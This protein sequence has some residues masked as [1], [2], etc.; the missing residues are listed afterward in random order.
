[1]ETQTFDILLLDFFH[2]LSIVLA[3]DDLFDARA[4]GGEYFFP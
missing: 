2:V 4:F 3:K 1:M